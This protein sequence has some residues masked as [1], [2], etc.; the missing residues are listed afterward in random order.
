MY[1]KKEY[2]YIYIKMQEKLQKS[3]LIGRFKNTTFKL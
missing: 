3:R 2:I 1:E